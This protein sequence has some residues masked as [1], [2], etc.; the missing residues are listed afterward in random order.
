MTA[1]VRTLAAAG[2]IALCAQSASA[3]FGGLRGTTL[4]VSA[5]LP[6]GDFDTVAQTGYGIA[7]RTAI[8]DPAERWSMRGSFGFDYFKG[9]NT[10]DNVQFIATTLDIVHRSSDAYYQFGGLGMYNTRFNP[11]GG[12]G[13]GPRSAQEFGLSG[14]IGVNFGSGDFRSFVEFAAT[15]VFTGSSNSSWFPV[16]IGLRF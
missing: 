16:R 14:G 11:S 1:I 8:G 13:L 5:N 4:A 9:K 2:A 15:T 3:Q 12:I 7:L 6:V 10:Y